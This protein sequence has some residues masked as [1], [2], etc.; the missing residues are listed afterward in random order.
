MFFSSVLAI[1]RI[2]IAVKSNSFHVINEEIVRRSPT[3]FVGCLEAPLQTLL[4]NQDTENFDVLR[5]PSS[6]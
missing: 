4:G 1:E 3:T 6:E 5:P 2:V